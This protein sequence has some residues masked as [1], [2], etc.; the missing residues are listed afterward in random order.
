MWARSSLC[1]L[2]R[3]R[4][5]YILRTPS[6]SCRHKHRLWFREGT[7]LE[8]YFETPLSSSRGTQRNFGQKSHLIIG[9]FGLICTH[10]HSVVA[11]ALIDLYI[12]FVGAIMSK[13][14]EIRKNSYG[15]GIRQYLRYYKLYYKNLQNVMTMNTNG[16]ISTHNK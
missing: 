14:L 16:S 7:Q 3:T 15:F 11:Y 9:M 5:A 6:K 4:Q 12:F 13:S 2:P 8:R 10:D 1:C